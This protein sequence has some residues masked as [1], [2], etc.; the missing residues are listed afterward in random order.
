VQE[1]DLKLG[2]TKFRQLGTVISIER[3]ALAHKLMVKVHKIPTLQGN[4]YDFFD[5]VYNSIT[6]GKRTC[7]WRRWIHANYRSCNTKVVLRKK[8]LIYR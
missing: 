1:D 3:R 4:Y 8:Q 7:Y 6:N 2:K 5:G